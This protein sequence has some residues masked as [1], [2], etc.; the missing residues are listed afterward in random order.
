MAFSRRCRATMP[1]IPFVFS[2]KG[3]EY[4]VDYLPA[5]SEQRAMFGG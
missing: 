5:E 2:T 3:T 4:R 1:I